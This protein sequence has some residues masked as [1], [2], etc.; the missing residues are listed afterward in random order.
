MGMWEEGVLGFWEVEK[1]DEI[2][3]REE[4]EEEEEEMACK[5]KRMVEGVGN[6]EG[7]EGGL[8]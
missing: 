5:G 3:E 4:D 6:S 1:G 8:H 2:A 7:E